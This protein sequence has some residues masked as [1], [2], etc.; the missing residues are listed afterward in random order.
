[1]TTIT[2]D[3]KYKQS[4]MKY[5]TAH[6]VTKA[7]RKYSRARSCICFWLDRWDGSVESLRPESRRPHQHPNEHTMEQQMEDYLYITAESSACFLGNALTLLD[8]DSREKEIRT[9]T[10]NIHRVIKYAK[11]KAG[12]DIMPSE[13]T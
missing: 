5:A 1:M 12:N 3:M 9:F 8:A 4:L 13:T 7:S 6:G 10:D 11:Q 2:Q